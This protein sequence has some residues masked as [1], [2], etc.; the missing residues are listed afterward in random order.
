MGS[1]RRGKEGR[2]KVRCE[3]PPQGASSLSRELVTP[4]VNA[5]MGI[6]LTLKC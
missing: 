4:A 1:S 3:W 2:L 6:M 5:H